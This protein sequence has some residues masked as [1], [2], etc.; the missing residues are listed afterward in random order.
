MREEDAFLDGASAGMLER[1]EAPLNG[2]L[3]FLTRDAE[4]AIDLAHI[5]HHPLALIRRGVRLCFETLGGELDHRQ[6]ELVVSG[7]LG[8]STGSITADSG[9]VVAEWDHAI[10][11]V[12]VVSE[13]GAFDEALSIPGRIE[14]PTFGWVLTSEEIEYDAGNLERAS[15][16]AFVDRDA[17]LGDLR[18]RNSRPGDRM[19]PVGFTGTRKLSDLIGEAHLTALARQRLPVL[20]DGE[21]PFWV[22]GV[23]LADR[24][25]TKVAGRTVKVTFGPDARSHLDSAT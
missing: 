4:I 17:L 3:G 15:L 13:N 11:H 20:C 8:G 10:F 9:S 16:Q 12:Y 6:T 14:A 19:R 25:A 23:M 18:V 22:P 21:G 1:L 7:I 5:R 24:I 2:V